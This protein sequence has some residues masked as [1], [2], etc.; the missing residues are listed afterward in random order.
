MI[1]NIILNGLY[2]N[3]AIFK[4]MLGLCPTLAVTTSATNALGMG[5]A[6]TAVLTGSNF[7][8]SLV[9]KYIPKNVRI[10]SYIVIIACFVT[11]IDQLMKA[12]LYSM[13]KVLGIFIPLIVVNCIVLGRAES[14]ASK[15]NPL[16]SLLDGLSVGIGFTIALL[17]LGSVREI[18]GAGTFF[19]MPVMLSSYNPLLIAI[20]PPGAFLFLGFIFA[21]KQFLDDKIKGGYQKVQKLP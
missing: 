2:N 13:H 9:A 12:N 5:L 14:F 20:L 3:N 16:Y 1:K 17:I 21:G 7:V 15:N 18:A 11:I 6:T 10:P 8:I 4:Q 19:N